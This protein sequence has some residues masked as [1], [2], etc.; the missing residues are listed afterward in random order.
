MRSERLWI[1]VLV[2]VA[3]AA[4]LAGG[5]LWRSAK[6]SDL[7]QHPFEPYFQ[8]LVSEFGLNEAQARDL[9]IALVEYGDKIDRLREAAPQDRRSELIAAGEDCVSKIREFI[10]PVDQRAEFDRL[11]GDPQGTLPN[12]TKEI[13]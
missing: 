4:G 9:G 8:R 5:I 6:P 3:F 2:L 11:L 1:L 7:A 10:I 12:E 13:H